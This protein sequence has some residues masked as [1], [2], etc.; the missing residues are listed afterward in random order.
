MIVK[1]ENGEIVPYVDF[2]SS[3]S[4]NN[5]WLSIDEFFELDEV[6]CQRDTEARIPRARKH[7]SKLQLEHC[8]VFVAKLAKDDLYNGKRY[9]AGHKFRIDSNTRNLFWQKG[10]SDNIPKSV[11]VIEYSFDTVDRIRESYNT[12]DSPNSV[13]RN[14]EKFYGMISGM[15]KYEPRSQKIKRGSILSG[16]NKAGC[17]LAPDQWN[18]PTVTPDIIL[19]QTCWF[20]PEIKAI[21]SILTKAD[22]WDQALFCLGLM[23]LKKYGTDNDRVL[24]GLKRINDRAYST[25]DKQMDGISHICCEWVNPKMFVDKTTLWHKDGGLDRTVAYACYWMDKWVKNETGSK[26]GPGWEQTAK[27]WKDQEVTTLNKCLQIS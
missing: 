6:F 4:I 22:C 26:L 12:F 13:E 21:D 19:A 8:T 18:Q 10:L 1:R 9:K 15:L 25:M 27:R 11:S 17:F 16:M 7:L 24:D 14:Q 23:S 3:K 20:L 5:Y 2:E